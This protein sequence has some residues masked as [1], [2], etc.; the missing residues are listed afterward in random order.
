MSCRRHLSAQRVLTRY[1]QSKRGSLL[2]LGDAAVNWLFAWD[3]N[4]LCTRSCRGG[5]ARCWL[6]H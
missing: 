2:I 4:C 3:P 6:P 1:L 5:A